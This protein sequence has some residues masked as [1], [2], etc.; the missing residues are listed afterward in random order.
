MIDFTHRWKAPT[1]SFSPL[2]FITLN[3]EHH[4]ENYL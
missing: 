2:I 1:S 4:H 3:K